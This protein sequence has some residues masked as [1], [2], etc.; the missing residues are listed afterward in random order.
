MA[1]AGWSADGGEVFVSGRRPFYFVYDVAAGVARRLPRALGRDD[2]SLETMVVQGAAASG[3]PPPA[4]GPLLAFLA[5]D[6]AIVLVSQRS[7]AW[8]STLKMNGAVR[9]AA[10]ARPPPGGSGAGWADIVAVGAEGEVYRWDVRTMRCS[11]RHADEG[12][13]GGTAIACSD[14][15]ARVAVG[16]RAGVVNVYDAAAAAA[17]GGSAGGAFGRPAARAPPPAA[18]SL[19][20]TTAVS[21]L[22]F[23]P[24]AGDALAMASQAAPDAL[25]VLHTPTGRAFANWPSARTPLGHVTSLAFSPRGGYAAVGNDKGRVLLYRLNH[26]PDA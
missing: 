25:R 18:T 24:G 4:S 12:S 17:A 23:S 22:A 1:S 13:A 2:K 7:K 20:L 10:F 16:S 11:A 9:A 6:G 26:W 14:D 5:A 8:V 21:S 19:A 3:A 15:G